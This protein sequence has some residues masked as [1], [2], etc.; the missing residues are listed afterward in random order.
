MT[1]TPQSPRRSPEPRAARDWVKLLSEYRDPDTTRSWFELAVTIGPFVLL[2]ALAWWSLGVSYWLTLALSSLNA[3]FLLRLFAIQ[4]DCG[5]GAFFRNRTLSDWLGRVL[6]VL[7]LTPYDVW[8]RSHS[9]H[10]S[11][12][13]NLGRRGMGDIHTLTVAEY[14][15]LTPYNRLMYRLYRH[16]LVLFGLGPGYLFFLQNRLPLGLMETARYW[17]SAMCTNAAIL[18]LLGLIFWFGGLMPILLIF[19]PSTLLA[20]TAGVWLFYVQHQFE[21]THWEAEEDWQ[22]HDAALHGSSHYVMPA[23]LQWLSANIGIHHVHHLHS[24][25]PFY[26]LPRVLRD[27]ADLATG[28]RMTIRES[29]QNA[30]LHLW[31]EDSR[32]L[33]SFREARTLIG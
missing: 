17:I 25:I 20:A 10:H 32:R 19:L 16:P 21:T 5:H 14:R 11:S 27:H 28:N 22:L 29:F 24:R 26:R 3:A 30:R 8:R 18:A 15:D 7:T 23:V 6:G 12:A 13:G 9:I 1:E 33:L 2:W 31:D 4:H